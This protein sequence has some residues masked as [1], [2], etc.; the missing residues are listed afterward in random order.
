MH[1]VDGDGAARRQRHALRADRFALVRQSGDAEEHIGAVGGAHRRGFL[2]MRGHPVANALRRHLLARDEIAFDE[3]AL[4]R[5][6]AITVVRIVADAQRRAVLEDHARRA[7]DLDREQVERILEPADLEFLPVERAGLDGAAIVIRHELVV[8]VTATDPRPFVRKC[9]GA[10]VV[11]GGDQITRPAVDRDVE[12]RTGKAR[13]RDH[14]LE[15]A[16]QQPLAL[17]QAR[18]ANGLKVPF[19]EGARGIRILRLQLD[20]VAA[21]V[22]QGSGNLCVIGALGLARGA[23]ARLIGGER[24]E[25]IIGRPARELAPLDRLE[26][27]A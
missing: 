9:N 27:A 4:D 11:A 24:G 5:A 8:P 14:R 3:H 13:A 12:F 16:G 19:E 17:A 10:G 22:P 23:A 1:P 7:F 21:D 2:G 15:I 26:L 18:D 25:M 6:V 20:G